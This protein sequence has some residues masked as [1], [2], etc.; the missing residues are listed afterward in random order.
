MNRMTP[1]RKWLTA[2]ETTRAAR[3]SAA[4]LALIGGAIHLWVAPEHYLEW[5]GYGLFFLIVASLQ[6]VL[7]AAL[8][9]RPR[10]WMFVAGILGN[11]SIAAL[12]AYTRTITV[13]LGPMAGEAE[14]VGA[15]DVACTS[16][17]AA[18]VLLLMALWWRFPNPQKKAS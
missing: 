6:S 16:V 10:R 1:T 3:H 8:L 18:L 13:P 12:W 9:F 7:A 17:E 15:L 11:L 4:A 14:A 5:P 2:H